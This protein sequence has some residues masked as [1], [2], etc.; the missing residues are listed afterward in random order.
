MK[1]N[2]NITLLLV[3][4]FISCNK[5]NT[6]TENSVYVTNS[7]SNNERIFLDFWL[8]MSKE[9]YDKHINT[10]LES[11]KIAAYYHRSDGSIEITTRNCDFDYSGN[12]VEYG[13]S[14]NFY[15][16][17]DGYFHE[18]FETISDT[19]KLIEIKI[20]IY[21]EGWESVLCGINVVG[22]IHPNINKSELD[23]IVKIY[24]EKYGVPVF[25]NEKL[26]KWEIKSNDSHKYFC[27]IDIEK[28]NIKYYLDKN[29]LADILK[30]QN[31]IKTN[32]EL[33]K[34]KLDI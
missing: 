24:K 3:V 34:S 8:L 9:D 2:F 32:Q 16:D 10:L 11:N 25:Q 12:G 15:G 17:I 19:F 26:T 4:C 18:Y 23:P 6:H 30:N 13:Y 31:N 21:K 5:N 20:E 14:Y 7:N 28:K 1:V 22:Y 33:N 29:E 27:E